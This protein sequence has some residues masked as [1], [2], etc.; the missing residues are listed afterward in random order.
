MWNRVNLRITA[1]LLVLLVWV[2]AGA[3]C[4]QVDM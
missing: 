2:A 3:D 1:L 4:Y